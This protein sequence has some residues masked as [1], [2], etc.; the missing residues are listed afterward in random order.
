MRGLAL[1]A[2]L[3]VSPPARDPELPRV[4]REVFAGVNRERRAAGL[5]PLAWNDA[6]AAEARRHA[7]NMAGRRFFAHEDPLRGGLRERLR[8]HHIVYRISAEN[9]YQEKGYKD[10]ATQAV[11]DWMKS[12]GHCR[13]ILDG[14]FTETGVGAAYSGDGTIF[15]SQVF[16]RPWPR[17]K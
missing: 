14:E 2:L 1:V 10:P 11:Q 16:I 17:K 12:P 7:L 15:M 3:V 13:N 9:I 4:E 5:A 8:E 6:V